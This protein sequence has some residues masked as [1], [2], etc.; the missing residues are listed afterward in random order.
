MTTD[1]LWGELPK[2]DNDESPADILRAQAK[3]LHEQTKYR[4]QGDVKTDSRDTT[5]ISE[6]TIVAPYLNGYE[7]T[8]ARVKHGPIMYPAK[9]FNLLSDEHKFV[10]CGDAESFKE[11]L[12][13]ILQSDQIRKVI[14]SLL[15]QSKK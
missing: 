2:P 11:A 9:L 7:I 1:N 4:L 5:I 8:V 6:L 3:V 12:S 10:V 15:A 14:S 13:R